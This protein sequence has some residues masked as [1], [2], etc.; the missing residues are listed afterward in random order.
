MH[1]FETIL[2]TV[3]SSLNIGILLYFDLFSVFD[4]QSPEKGPWK[5]NLLDFVYDSFMECCPRRDF[6]QKVWRGYVTVSSHLASQIDQRY[7]TFS[8]IEDIRDNR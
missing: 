6:R 4:R 7:T 2:Y 3:R 5:V 1:I 8:V